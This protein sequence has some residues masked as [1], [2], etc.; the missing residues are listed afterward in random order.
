MYAWKKSAF[1]IIDIIMQ[2]KSLKPP[3]CYEIHTYKD[4]I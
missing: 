1:I 3:N 4:C 2:K